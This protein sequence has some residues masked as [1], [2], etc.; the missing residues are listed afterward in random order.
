MVLHPLQESAAFCNGNHPPKSLETAG[1]P[2]NLLPTSLACKG[3]STKIKLHSFVAKVPVRRSWADSYRAT[4]LPHDSVSANI[5]CAC[6][7]G[8]FKLSVHSAAL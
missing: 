6:T 4:E 7:C 8:K 5:K 3:M 2:S 1:P